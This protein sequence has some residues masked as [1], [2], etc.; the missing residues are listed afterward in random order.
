MPCRRAWSVASA[1]PP[2][3]RALTPD[4]LRQLAASQL[5][6]IGADTVDHVRLGGRPPVDQLRTIAAS[7]TELEAA[8]GGAVAHFAYPFGRQ[9]DFDDASVAAVEQAGFETACTTL[10][11]TARPSSNRALLPRRLVMNWGRGRFRAQLQRW[12]LG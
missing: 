6:T 12:R 3:A 5:V 7:K 1:A 8:I 2:D 9:G 11:G 4:E 10:P